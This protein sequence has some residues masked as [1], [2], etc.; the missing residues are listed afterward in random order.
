MSAVA[1]K[2]DETFENLLLAIQNV[3]V[4]E[5]F[6]KIHMNEVRIAAIYLSASVMDCLSGLIEWV[7]ASS[8]FLFLL[9]L[10]SVLKQ[11]LMAPDFDD[12]VDLVHRRLAA[13]ATALQ[14]KRI[15]EEQHDEILEWVCG[16]STN[17]IIPQSGKEFGD[18][19]HWF[20]DGPEYRDWVGQGPSTLICSGKGILAG[21][22]HF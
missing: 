9:T 5:D 6:S 7:D 20:V 4:V 10:M 8:T 12:K 2:V 16:S 18:T 21:G 3:G 13:Y 19:C 1:D 14:L 15:R 22:R 17:Y 11:A